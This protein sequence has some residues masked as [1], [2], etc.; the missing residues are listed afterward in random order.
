MSNLS[1]IQPEKLKVKLYDHQLI[2]IRRMEKMED[3]QRIIK[4]DLVKE[5]KIGINA[6][7]TGYGKTLSTIGLILRNKM[8]WD[9]DLPYIEEKIITTNNLI[10]SHIIKR[11]EKLNCNLILVSPSIIKQW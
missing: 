6:D 2:S 7:P 4:K 1:I 5:F 9:I 10:K 8:E 11:Y 3:E